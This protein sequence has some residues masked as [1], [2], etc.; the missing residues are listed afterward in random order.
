MDHREEWSDVFF[1]IMQ[2]IGW[3]VY[4][5]TVTKHIMGGRLLSRGHVSMLW[6][7]FCWETLNP[8]IHVFLFIET[9]V[10][11]HYQQDKALWHKTRMEWFEKQ[12]QCVNLASKFP[13]FQS[14]SVKSKI[15]RP[16]LDS[17]LYSPR[18]GA[19]ASSQKINKSLKQQIQ[20]LQSNRHPFFVLCLEIK[21]TKKQEQSRPEHGLHAVL[22]RVVGVA[23]AAFSSDSVHKPLGAAFRMWITELAEKKSQCSHLF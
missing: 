20:N 19:V 7:M 8:A 10:S 23:T 13:I 3:I 1:Y 18:G 12:V 14:S 17:W 15:W 2:V 16:H 4:Y 9:K 5:S 22:K 6:G 11:S 21:Q